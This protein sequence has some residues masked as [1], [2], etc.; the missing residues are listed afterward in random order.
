MWRA[1]VIRLWLSYAACAAIV[2]AYPAWASAQ[3]DQ[4]AT[5]DR[6]S[7]EQSSRQSDSQEDQQNRQPADREPWDDG[8]ARDRNQQGDQ[9]NR[10]QSRDQQSRDQQYRDQQDRSRRERQ[11]FGRSEQMTDG[12]YQGDRRYSSGNSSQGQDAGLGVRLAATSREEI[13]Q[14]GILV[15]RVYSGSAAEEMGLEAGDR[16]THLNGERIQSAQQFVT[17]IR[18]MRPGEEIELEVQRDDR[19]RNLSGELESRQEALVFSNRPWSRQSGESWRTERAYT[20]DSGR[21]E[22]G[23][24][25]QYDNQ[26]MSHISAIERQ[27]AQLSRELEE[28]RFAVRARGGQSGQA[29]SYGGRQDQETTASYEYQTGRRGEDQRSTNRWSNETYEGSYPSG[30]YNEGYRGRSSGSDEGVDSIGGEIG[31]ERLRPGNERF[32]Q[33]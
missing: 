1:R 22:Q 4:Q 32:E 28:L 18:D 23:R 9:R 19:E 26:L 2:L 27:I 14:R 24:S 10:E 15:D 16:V 20:G 3:R 30:Q 29:G 6:Q 17:Q 33:P 5:S 8:S 31:E 25:S 13:E 7:S 12:G 11:E 21:F